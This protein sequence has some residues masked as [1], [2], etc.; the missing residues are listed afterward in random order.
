M[1]SDD[2]EA[3]TDLT[4]NRAI[5]V[6]GPD[7]C[8]SCGLAA[9]SRPIGGSFHQHPPRRTTSA[10]HPRTPPTNP[11]DT[12]RLYLFGF[13]E[14]GSRGWRACSIP[15]GLRV[16]VVASIPDLPFPDRLTLCCFQLEDVPWYHRPSVNGTNAAQP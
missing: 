13:R 5:T 4:L 3:D 9:L 7:F 15:I 2:E 12:E 1:P 10:D 6:L 11:L 14:G 16:S 8:D